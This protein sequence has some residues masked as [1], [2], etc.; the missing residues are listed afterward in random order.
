MV[1]YRVWRKSERFQEILYT[2]RAKSKEHWRTRI[3]TGNEVE[4]IVLFKRK[5]L[6]SLFRT[7]I[8]DEK[9]LQCFIHSKH[10]KHIYIESDKNYN[11]L[12][13]RYV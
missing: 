2:S 11:N 12:R 3:H 13:N 6:M 8:W 5:L 1:D 4:F 10:L 9:C 7:R